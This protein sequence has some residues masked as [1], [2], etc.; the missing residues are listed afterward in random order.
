MHADLTLYQKE[1]VRKNAGT[2]LPGTGTAGEKSFYPL[3]FHRVFWRVSPHFDHEKEAL[4]L[5][6]IETELLDA[7]VKW[8]DLEGCGRT[9]PHIYGPIKAEAIRQVLPY[10]R[11]ED[12]TWK[13][14]PEL[15]EI[16]DR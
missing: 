13:K 2:D 12:G 16:A 6:V 5:L 4:L 3:F 14:N 15:A 11:K 8:E 1:S 9:Y 7:P 10:L